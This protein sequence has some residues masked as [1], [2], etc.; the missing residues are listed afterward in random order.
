MNFTLQREIAL[1]LVIPFCAV[2]VANPQEPILNPHIH[3]ELPVQRVKPP[4]TAVFTTT[5][6]AVLIIKD[7]RR[8]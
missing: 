7:G 6:G 4:A 1:G 5:V 8:G 2:A 3:F